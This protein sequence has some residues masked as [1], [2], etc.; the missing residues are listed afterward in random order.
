MCICITIHFALV[1]GF[2]SQRQVTVADGSVA[3]GYSV[4]GDPITALRSEL[5]S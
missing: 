2:T 5:L 1:S 3:S 4:I